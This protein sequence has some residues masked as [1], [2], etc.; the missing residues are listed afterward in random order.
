MAFKQAS[1]GFSW[2]AA[3]AVTRGNVRPSSRQKAAGTLKFVDMSNKDIFRP[4]R[5]NRLKTSPTYE[6][7]SGTMCRAWQLDSQVSIM[8]SRSATSHIP[9]HKARAWDLEN[10]SPVESGS[11]SCGSFAALG[12]YPRRTNAAGTGQACPEIRSIQ[13]TCPTGVR[14]PFSLK[15]G[16]HSSSSEQRGSRSQ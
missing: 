10:A 14:T 12:I 4:L 9:R 16:G 6:A 8:A 15:D 7:D 1:A 11:V 13:S 2:H 5:S 3:P